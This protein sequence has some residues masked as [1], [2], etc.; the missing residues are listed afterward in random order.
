FKTVVDARGAVASTKLA[1]QRQDLL[2]FQ[3]LVAKAVADAN[4][5][6]QFYKT[7]A[8]VGIQNEANR[9]NAQIQGANSKRAF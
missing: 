6:H 9:M 7:K 1:V 3:E 2:A 5:K 4:L 8:D